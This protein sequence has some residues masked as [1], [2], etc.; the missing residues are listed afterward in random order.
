MN[1]EFSEFD[2]SLF[3]F[4]CLFFRLDFHVSEFGIPCGNSTLRSWLRVVP[5]NDSGSLTDIFYAG[6]SLFYHVD[7]EFRD[8]FV[9]DNDVDP[10]AIQSDTVHW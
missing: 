5:S 6:E 2:L 1:E 3:L 8:S 9:C 10:E 4:F 7:N